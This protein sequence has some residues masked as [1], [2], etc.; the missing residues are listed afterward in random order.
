MKIIHEYP[1]KV[2]KKEHDGRTYYKIGLSHKDINGNYV[3]GYLEAK[4]RKDIEVDDS[5]KIYIKDSWL[6]FYIVDK[7]T[8]PYIFINQF[9]YV[10][11]VVKQDTKDPFEN[12]GKVYQDEIELDDKDLPF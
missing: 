9:E 1:I 4:F 6:D 7:I 3:N 10:S 2:F 5:K 12:A 8:R 11:D